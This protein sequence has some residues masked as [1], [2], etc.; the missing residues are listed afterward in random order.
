MEQTFGSTCHGAGR[1]MSRHA[2][3]AHARGRRIDQE[4]AAK[5]IIARA[6]ARTGLAEE[7]SDAYK[8]I[9]L[10]A[11]CVHS[12]GLST[13]VARLKPIGVIKG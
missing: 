11:Q 4:L 7:Q 10:V 3:I 13:K 1:V 5:G 6:R 12:A 8:D 2:A 9:D